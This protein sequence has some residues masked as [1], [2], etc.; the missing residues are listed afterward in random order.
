[1]DWIQWALFSGRLIAGGLLLLGGFSK[2]ALGPASFLKIVQA[3]RLLPNR[4]DRMVAVALPPVEAAAGLFLVLGTFARLSSF[5]GVIVLAAVTS[6]AITVLVRGLR[7]PCGCMGD[8]KSMVTWKIVVRNGLLIASLAP[9][10][11]VG[12]SSL[13]L[14]SG[15]AGVSYPAVGALAAILGLVALRARSIRAYHVNQGGWR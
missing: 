8:F 6:A 3:Y 13:S 7:A 9:G 2:I 5:L 14:V 15:P 4:W 12:G 11:V 10:L 1:M